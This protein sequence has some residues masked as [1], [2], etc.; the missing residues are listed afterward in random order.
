MLKRSKQY[1][2]TS[3]CF[4]VDIPGLPPDV[5]AAYFP[6]KALVLKIN[7]PAGDLLERM[8]KGTVP[9]LDKW[10]RKFLENLIKVG[11]VNG[12][13]DKIPGPAVTET[14]KPERT[15][16][17]TSDRCNLRCIYCYG[18]SETHGDLM[19][20]GIAKAAID[21]IISNATELGMNFVEV[22]FHGGGEPTINWE[23][24]TGAIEYAREEC[25]KNNLRLHS[26]IC[27]NGVMS[28]GRIRWIGENI[29]GIVISVDGPPE[30]HNQQRPAADGGP[31]FNIAARSIDIL[32]SMKKEY[33]LRLTA[34]AK[35]E[36]I[37]TDISNFLIERFNPKAICI[38]P[39]FICGRCDTAQCDKPDP[40]IFSKEIMDL[41]TIKQKNGV[42]IQYSGGRFFYLDSMFCGAA[43]KN[44]FITPRGEVTSCLEIS[45]HDD[46]RSE[47]FIYGSFDSDRNEFVFDNEKYSKLCNIRVDAFESC[48]DCFIKWNCAGDCPAKAP[49]FEHIDTVRYSYRCEINKSV[50]K[51]QLMKELEII[52]SH[53]PQAL[54]K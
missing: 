24:L 21:F 42:D 29:G 6:L 34:T 38:E 32:K 45:K 44:F 48:R 10:E 2:L 41:I 35:S 39:L 51:A 50:T 14:P 12:P 7:K 11:L 13:A 49:D 30:I 52:K 31:S 20:F 46:P 9:E 53:D 15:I 25:R 26:Q 28:E 43:G 16:L 8:K 54:S 40:D 27:T 47:L 4:I 17:L 19:P 37:L 22:G 36:G 33:M 5:V 1:N 3:E 18:K 23:V